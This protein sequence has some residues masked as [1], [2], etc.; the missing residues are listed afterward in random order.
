M[1]VPTI[2]GYCGG[3]GL[4]PLDIGTFLQSFE[5]IISMFATKHLP[6]ESLYSTRPLIA[7]GD[8]INAKGFKN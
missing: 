2:A 5:S 3:D 1:H 7:C 4:T 6:I 8:S